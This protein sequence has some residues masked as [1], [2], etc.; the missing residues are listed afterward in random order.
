MDMISYMDQV[1]VSN[2][3]YLIQFVFVKYAQA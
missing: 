1:V 2:V 3:I